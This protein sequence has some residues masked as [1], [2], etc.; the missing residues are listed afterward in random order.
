MINFPDFIVLISLLA[1]LT[2]TLLIIHSMFKENKRISQDLNTTKNSWHWSDQRVDE[3]RKE[4]KGLEAM[5]KAAKPKPSTV[6]I[7][8]QN[9]GDS[10]TEYETTKQS[11]LD[12]QEVVQKT[13]NLT[14][15]KPF[16]L[17]TTSGNKVALDRGNLLRINIKIGD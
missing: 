11:A 15:G 10:T 4:N 12:L 7:I 8:Y 5:A 2:I 1:I 13:T 14:E 16:Q 17:E 9:R 3:L 6:Q